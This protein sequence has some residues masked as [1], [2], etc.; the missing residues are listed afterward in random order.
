[1]QTVSS[2]K[3]LWLGV[4]VWVIVGLGLILSLIYGSGLVKVLMIAVTLFVGWIWFFTNYSFTKRE[5]VIKCG[6][7]SQAIP[8]SSI[9]GVERIRHTGLSYALSADRVELKLSGGGSAFI[10]PE[11]PDSFVAQIKEKAPAL[12]EG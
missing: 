6:P 8:L 4:V 11:N 10:S 1:M 12:N 3:D 7:F 9:V 5:L 2:K